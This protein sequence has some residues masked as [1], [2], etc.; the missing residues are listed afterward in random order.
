VENGRAVI[1]YSKCTGCGVCA[2][3]CPRKVIHKK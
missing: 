2:D 1:D 3:K